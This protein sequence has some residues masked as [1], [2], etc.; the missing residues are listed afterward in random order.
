MNKNFR[1]FQNDL[2]KFCVDAMFNV[3]INL[4]DAKLTAEVLATTDSWGIYS[5]GTRQLRMIKKEN[6]YSLMKQLL[7]KTGKK[8]L[9][10]L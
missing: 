2:E 8:Q 4:E 7:L 3:G 9:N 5:H 6:I 10:T 1:I